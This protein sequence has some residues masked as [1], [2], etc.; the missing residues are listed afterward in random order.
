MR[1][2]RADLEA[3]TELVGRLDGFEHRAESLIAELESQIR[4]L[5]GQWSG[6]AAQ[7]HL[8]AHRRWLS[9][10]ERM[11]GAAADLR[12]RVDAARTNYTA[13]AEANTRMWS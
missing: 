8:D 6:L 7:A 1:G 2:F 5:H 10:A 3:L 9:G 13:A 11:R 4:R 12:T